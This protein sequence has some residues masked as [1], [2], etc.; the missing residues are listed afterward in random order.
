[1]PRLQVC[2]LRVALE[3]WTAGSQEPHYVG[4]QAQLALQI[5]LLLELLQRLEIELCTVTAIAVR[6]NP[7]ITDRAEQSM[8][9]V[10][11]QSDSK[12]RNMK[13]CSQPLA[14]VKIDSR[15]L[16]DLMRRHS[17]GS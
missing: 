12:Q 15:I 6:A 5:D 10:T 7:C 8:Q 2:W 9:T 16:T 17:S 11:R 3:C 1:M 4:V 13:P 14:V